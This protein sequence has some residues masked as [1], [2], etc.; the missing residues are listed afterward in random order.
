MMT[1]TGVA[2]RRLPVLLRLQPQPLR[3][4][5]TTRSGST[6]SSP[7]AGYEM[8]PFDPIIGLNEEFQKDPSPHKVIVGVGA[9]RDDSGKPYVLPVVRKAEK[10]IMDAQLDMEYSTIVSSVPEMKVTGDSLA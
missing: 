8:A 5:M 1:T 4:T 10:L 7:F 9:Y 6:S 2:S 3:M